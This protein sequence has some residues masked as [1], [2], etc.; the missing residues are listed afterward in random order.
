MSE[1][2][3]EKEK[4]ERKELEKAMLALIEPTRAEEGCQE[5]ELFLSTE[6]ENRFTFI[7]TWTDSNALDKHLQTP[8]LQAFFGQ[9]GE[10]VEGEPQILKLKLVR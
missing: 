1:E 10:W 3:A 6:D 7:E 8:P 4:E 2:K 5:Y 9:V